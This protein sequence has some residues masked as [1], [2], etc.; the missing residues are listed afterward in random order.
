MYV[1]VPTAPRRALPSPWSTLFSGCWCE[2][3]QTAAC[4]ENPPTAFS[5]GGRGPTPHKSGTSFQWANVGVGGSF[6]NV[7]SVE[8]VAFLVG[9]HGR[10]ISREKS[11]VDLAVAFHPELHP[12]PDSV[13]GG[14]PAG[15]RLCGPCKRLG[16]HLT[17]QWFSRSS[18]A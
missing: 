14:W 2:L 15:P 16:W 3:S 7:P 11:H 8:R 18:G 13:P 9:R 1:A 5:V 4:S 10:F 17:W 6:F 12:Q